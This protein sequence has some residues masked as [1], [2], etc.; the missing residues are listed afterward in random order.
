MRYDELANGACNALIWDMR[1]DRFLFLLR[2]EFCTMPL[3]WCLPGGHL[4]PGEDAMH[5]ISREIREELGVDLSD[6]PTIQLT[7]TETQEPYFIHR[8]FAM[9]VPKAFSPGLNWEHVEHRWATM[10]E[11][12]RP[13]VWSLDMLLSNDAAGEKLKAWQERLRKAT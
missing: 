6:A 5:C 12:P 3:Q 1:T 7:E 13:T 11:M 9:A 4:E 10:E 2:S 8:N